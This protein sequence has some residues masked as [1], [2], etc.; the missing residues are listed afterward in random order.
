L[1]TILD[2][3]VKSPTAALRFI[4]RHCGVLVSTPHSSRFTSLAFGAFYFAV[5]F[6]DFLRPHHFS[7]KGNGHKFRV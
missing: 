6:F 1:V 5:A 2:G 4:F 7:V 3:F